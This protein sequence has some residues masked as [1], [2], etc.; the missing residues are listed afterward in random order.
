VLSRTRMQFLKSHMPSVRNAKHEH[1]MYTIGVFAAVCVVADLLVSFLTQLS[2][3]QQ[4][5]GIFFVVLSVIA[6]FVGSRDAGRK[7]TDTRNASGAQTKKLIQTQKGEYEDRKAGSQPA[8]K[9]KKST[10][11]R[12]TTAVAPFEDD[13]EAIQAEQTAGPQPEL[14]QKHLK[15]PRYAS[16]SSA[17]THIP[18]EGEDIT[19]KS[20]DVVKL[21]QSEIDARAIE[22]ARAEGMEPSA[23]AHSE[24][25]IACTVSNDGDM[26]LKLL[27]L[28][29]EKDMNY[30]YK[31]VA[32][33]ADTGS[34]FFSLVAGQLDDERLRNEGLRIL[35]VVR[36]HGIQPPHILQN[37]L[38]CAWGSKLPE[39][40]LEYFAKMRED[41]FA[42]SSA[43]CRCLVADM[44]ASTG[45]GGRT[46][47]PPVDATTSQNDRISDDDEETP[48]VEQPD[49]SQAATERTCLRR[50]AST[51]V[52]NSWEGPWQ[53][54]SETSM[55]C[56]W[57]PYPLGQDEF[58][59]MAM[60]QM[61]SQGDGA[62]VIV[63]NL[64][65]AFLR[66]H[67]IA[68]M[69]AK[70]FAGLYNIV[71]MPIDF[72]T[73]MSKGYAFVNLVTAD[74]IQR[75]MVAF[76][77]FRDWPHPSSTSA[78]VCAVD[79]AGTQGF[80]ANFA[81]YRNSP[82]MFDGVPER[83]RPA[84]FNGTVRVPWPEPTMELHKNTFESVEW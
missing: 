27:D 23:S 10:Q 56:S 65:C 53:M 72:K 70:G 34:R 68:Q 71:Y 12:V 61:R 81:R 78:K 47:P 21:E 48:A 46:C 80:A 50:E 54:P 55:P 76:N 45:E 3:A 63:R 33:L 7:K 1:Y 77:G 9:S 64:P 35:A 15:A 74:E 25:M 26:A 44:V 4:Q 5:N 2:E 83:F 13:R 69:D 75:F 73:K 66:E 38:V 57:F 49:V 29:L 11:A 16:R 32:A 36:A 67:L 18:T 39:Q 43:A 52:P 20:F 60:Q 30:D 82:G 59:Q 42:L 19:N 51:F 14:P 37:R 58:P 40:V 17:G 79:M 6:F 22:R 28:I 8:K 62:T 24:S 84:L 41:G 31:P